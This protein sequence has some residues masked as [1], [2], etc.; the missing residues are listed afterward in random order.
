MAAG[1]PGLLLH[2]WCRRH[3]LLHGIKAKPVAWEML[4]MCSVEQKCCQPP[5]FVLC[6]QCLGVV[7]VAGAV[8]EYSRHLW[9]ELQELCWGA[10]DDY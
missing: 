10:G 2:C 7:E 8:E 4:M 5:Q 1:A 3:L 6:W 9:K